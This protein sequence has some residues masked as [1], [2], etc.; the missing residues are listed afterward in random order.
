MRVAMVLVV[1]DVDAD[2]M[3]QRR[4]FQPLA[5][6]VLQPVHAARLVEHRHRE[7]RKPGPR[8][9]RSSCS[10]RPSSTTLRRHVGIAIGPRDLGAVP[11]DVVEH[12]PFAQRQVAERDVLGAQL[13]QDRCPE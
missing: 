5:L 8:A 11:V 13:A 4:V 10:V 12:Q 3:Q 1:A 6:L 7:A 2:V 9:A